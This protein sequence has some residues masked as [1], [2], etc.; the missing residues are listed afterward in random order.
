MNDLDLLRDADP[1]ADPSPAVLARARGVL[2]DA[3]SAGMPYESLR[4]RSRRRRLSVAVASVAAV[5]AA[6][7][8]VPI[9]ATPSAP[10]GQGTAA[11]AFLL[12]AAEAAASQDRPDARTARYWYV[13]SQVDGALALEK[14][15]REVWI[16]RASD[17]VLV[18]EGESPIPLG[19]ASFFGLTWEELFALPT[20]TDALRTRV[21]ALAG[22]AGPGPDAEAFV[23][24]G[25]LLRESPAPAPLRAALLRVAATIPGVALGESTTDNQGR[26]VVP[27]SRQQ[28]GVTTVLLMD[29]ETGD[30]H[31][32]ESVAEKGSRQ[33]PGQPEL[34]PGT[35]TYRSTTLV[36][37]PAESTDRP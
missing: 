37:G 16:G 28:D 33:R 32:E 12:R 9:L 29:P 6:L 21:Y 26:A 18:N 11:Q 35:V 13:R 3:T 31:G 23:V 25:D 10:S 27:V 30:L 19:S 4:P 7:L 14:G 15:V 22:D 2:T 17:G 34:P 36:A 8:V 24:V 1:A 5:A 20:D